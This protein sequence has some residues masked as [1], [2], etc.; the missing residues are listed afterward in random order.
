MLSTS[1]CSEWK[2]NNSTTYV[3]ILTSSRLC[4][5]CIEQ[6]MNA[7]TYNLTILLNA[8]VS[9]RTNV[10]F[11]MENRL[12]WR[13][14]VNIKQPLYVCN[15]IIAKINDFMLLEITAFEGYQIWMLIC[16]TVEALSQILMFEVHRGHAYSNR[17]MF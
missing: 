8:G 6:N 5:I 17:E 11:V 4:R 12:L 15:N 10:L 9:N 1:T 13:P 7:S 16:Q 3:A 14:L 2:I